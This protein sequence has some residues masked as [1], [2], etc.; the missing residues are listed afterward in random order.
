VPLAADL[1]STPQREKG[2]QTAQKRFGYQAKWALSLVLQ[3]HKIDEDYAVAV[4]FHDDVVLLNSSTD[5]TSL[6][7][8]QVK[9]KGTGHWTIGP[10]FKLDTKQS[11]P[12]SF[13]GKLFDNYLRFSSHTASLNFVSNSPCS[14][15]DA[16]VSDQPFSAC[17]KLDDFEKFKGKLKA[18]CAE[19][20][21]DLCKLFRFVL[22]DLSLG[23]PDAHT[24]GK[25][26]E[27][28]TE[29]IGHATPFA[30]RGL[31]LL[32]TTEFTRRSEADTP[33]GSLADLIRAKAVTKSD[34][35]RWLD[36]VRHK[37]PLPKWD[38]V[39]GQLSFMSPFEFARCYDEWTRYT[40]EV[41]DTGNQ[42]ILKVR[43]LIQ[44]ALNCCD[45]KWS[46]EQILGY[47]VEEVAA[48]GQDIMPN[49]THGKLKAMT[50]YEVL[51]GDTKP[52][53]QTSDAQPQD[54][55]K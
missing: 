3:R 6:A 4:E 51:A 12:A 47:C 46:W 2:G 19:V 54:E 37:R 53:I 42:A 11:A 27:F 50:L 33:T 20:T 48:R 45:S 28:V 16:S 22:S 14:F 24:L 21:D 55:E 40:G 31:Y 8:Y 18:E 25:I 10:L 34:V 32:F 5:P 13:M 43:G 7:F 29:E 41:L 17:K 44:D 52:E 26:V 30:P 23:D 36:A 1:L 49:L 35:E 38:D 15:L 39:S 9:T